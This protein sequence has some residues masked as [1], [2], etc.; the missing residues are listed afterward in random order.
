MSQA[1]QNYS[2]VQLAFIEALKEKK[3]PSLDCY[4]TINNYISLDENGEFEHI[5][6]YVGFKVFEAGYFAGTISRFASIVK[7]AKAIW[8]DNGMVNREEPEEQ[9]MAKLIPWLNTWYQM[10]PTQI[11]AIDL[12]LSTL[13]ADDLE[14]VCCGEETEQEILASALVNNFLNLI[15]DERYDFYDL[16]NIADPE[17]VEGQDND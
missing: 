8:Y 6:T 15:F 7:A 16:D 10:Y 13:S 3:F 14:T 1:E 2:P 5:D 17:A 4:L 12:E 9:H 11:T